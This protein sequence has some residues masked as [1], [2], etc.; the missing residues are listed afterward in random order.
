MGVGP[1]N[2]F[3]VLKIIMTAPEWALNKQKKQFIFCR[4]DYSLEKKS[5]GE[6]MYYVD[7]GR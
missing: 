3:I 1:I 6:I 5:H 2:I 7:K 4:S